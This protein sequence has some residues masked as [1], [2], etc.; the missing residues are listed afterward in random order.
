MQRLPFRDAESKDQTKMNLTRSTAKKGRDKVAGHWD[1]FQGRLPTILLMG[2]GR[3][4]GWDERVTAAT[5]L[6]L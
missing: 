5:L 3:S 1:E 4:K 6:S 2:T